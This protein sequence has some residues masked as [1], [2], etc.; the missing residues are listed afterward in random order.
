ML[1]DEQDGDG[2]QVGHLD[3]DI[4]PGVDRSDG[5]DIEEEA[6]HEDGGVVIPPQQPH[7]GSQDAGIPSERKMHLD[8]L[9]WLRGAGLYH[10]RSGL[11]TPAPCE[12]IYSVLS[13]PARCPRIAR[14]LC[15]GR[16]T[17]TIAW[18]GGVVTAPARCRV[19]PSK[20]EKMKTRTLI[21]TTLCCA[22]SLAC[23]T[24]QTT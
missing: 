12:R 1:Q 15:C 20:E 14:R 4:D 2:R 6:T 8:A 16:P 7:G 17:R 11:T 3:G 18:H 24:R 21:A 5:E 13:Q 9:T 19:F 22:L 10:A 23:A